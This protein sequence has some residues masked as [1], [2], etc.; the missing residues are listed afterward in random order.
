MFLQGRGGAFALLGFL[1]LLFFWN[2]LVGFP[3]DRTFFWEDFLYQNYPYRAFEA[4]EVRSGSFPFW[5]PYQFGGMPF[6]ADVQAASFYP[7]NLLL[8]LV[9]HDG[10]LDPW[11]VELEGIVHAFLGG[12]FLF[13][14]VRSRT[15]SVYA[16]LVAAAGPYPTTGTLRRAGR[17]ASE[18]DSRIDDV[19][20]GTRRP[21]DRLDCADPRSRHGRRRSGRRLHA[22]RVGRDRRRP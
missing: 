13:A 21:G 8:S 4:E 2:T 7:P 19:D 18:A 9:V 6:A 14:L 10:R 17:R 3:G 20:R 5:N 15:G 16:S 12:I 1:L 11:W 22:R